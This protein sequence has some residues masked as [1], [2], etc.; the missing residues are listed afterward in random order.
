MVGEDSNKKMMGFS[1]GSKKVNYGALNDFIGGYVAFHRGQEADL[2]RLEEISE[3]KFG[4]HLV[5]KDYSKQKYKYFKKYGITIPWRT[6]DNKK[7]PIYFNPRADI[8]I[9]K[10]N[11][12]DIEKFNKYVNDKTFKDSLTSEKNFQERFSSKPG[13]FFKRIGIAYKI[14]MG[15]KA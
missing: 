15:K 12:K 8:R 1:R 9:E 14:I 2:G 11:K 7:T 5:L 3:D 4:P 6:I 13:G 10:I